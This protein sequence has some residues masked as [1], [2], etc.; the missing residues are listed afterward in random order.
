MERV[1]KEALLELKAVSL[2]NKE[3]RATQLSGKE[4]AETEVVAEKKEAAE[5]QLLCFEEVGEP[6]T[7]A[8]Q[9]DTEAP[10]A[11]IPKS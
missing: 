4:G 5:P 6:A 3:H 2:G 7:Q 11:K 1:G 9:I 10:A 8:Q